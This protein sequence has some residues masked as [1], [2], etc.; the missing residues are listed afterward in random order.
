[1]VFKEKIFIHLYFTLYHTKRIVGSHFFSLFDNKN[2]TP[3]ITNF[4]I[5]IYLLGACLGA[6]LVKMFLAIAVLLIMFPLEMC[7]KRIVFG[8][9]LKKRV[10]IVSVQVLYF[11]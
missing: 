10:F 4:S 2:F 3:L 11:F 7:L 6:I 5:K 1:M 9:V 8:Y